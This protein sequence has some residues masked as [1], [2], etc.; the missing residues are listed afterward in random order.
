MIP[1]FRLMAA[2]LLAAGMARAGWPRAF[3]LESPR[4]GDRIEGRMPALGEGWLAYRTRD[5]ELLV[6][7]AAD[8]RTIRRVGFPLEVPV[9]DAGDEPVTLSGIHSGL[10][11][12]G[13]RLAALAWGRTGG[14]LAVRALVLWEIPSGRVVGVRIVPLPDHGEPFLAISESA[15]LLHLPGEQRLERWDPRDFTPGPPLALPEGVD[16]PEAASQIDGADRAWLGERFFVY[17]PAVEFAPLVVVDLVDGDAERIELPAEYRVRPNLVRVAGA[18]S[19]CLVPCWG[20]AETSFSAVAVFDLEAGRFEHA[21]VL[22]GVP[23]GERSHAFAGADGTWHVVAWGDEDRLFSFDRGDPTGGPGIDLALGFD[24]FVSHGSPYR[25][26][27]GWLWLRAGPTAPQSVVSYRIPL[28]VRPQAMIRFRVGKARESDGVVTA[29]WDVDPPLE[30]PLTLRLE[31]V[32]G[33]ARE[34][35]DYRGFSKQVTI[36]AGVASVPVEVALTRDLRIE[37][38]E[39][40]GLRLSGFDD[41]LI[42][43]NPL[44][45]V[46]IEGSTFY[47]EGL[48]EPW[49]ANPEVRARSVA[50]AGGWLVQGNGKTDYDYTLTPPRLARRPLRGGEWVPSGSWPHFDSSNGQPSLMEAAVE[51]EV[52]IYENGRSSLY[53]PAA[54][55][56]V[57]EFEQLYNRPMAVTGG[58]VIGYTLGGGVWQFGWRPGVPSHALP[59]IGSQ[60]RVTWT[61]RFVVSGG[62]LNESIEIGSRGDGRFLRRLLDEGPWRDIEG[63]AAAGDTLVVGGFGGSYLCRLEELD[64]DGGGPLPAIL[65]LRHP[66]EGAVPA[67]AIHVAGERI[68]AVRPIEGPRVRVEVFR[69]ADGEWTGTID[70]PTLGVPWISGFLRNLSVD[71]QDLVLAV[72]RD[73]RLSIGHFALDERIPAIR[74]SVPVREGAGPVPMQLSEAAPWPMVV[75]ARPIDEDLAEGEQWRGL[76]EPVTVPAGVTS[77]RLPLAREH[78]F[79]A[80]EPGMVRLELTVETPQGGGVRVIEVATVDD[81]R[82]SFEQ[83]ERTALP[84]VS[85]LTAFGNGWIGGYYEGDVASNDRMRWTDTP[86]FSV[87]HPLV[88]GA[89]SSSYELVTADDEWAA[90]RLPEVIRNFGGTPA[91]VILFRPREPEAPIRVFRGSDYRDNFGRSVLIDDGFVWIGAPWFDRLSTTTPRAGKVT[92]YDLGTGLVK[93]RITPPAA[94]KWN[95]GTRLVRNAESLWVASPRA[96]DEQGAVTQY[97]AATYALQRVIWAPRV[98]E[99]SAGFGSRLEATGE[100]LIVESP[101]SNPYQPSSFDGYEASTGAHLWTLAGGGMERVG[102]HLLVLTDRAGLWFHD[103]REPARPR[104][105]LH[106]AVAFGRKD[107]WIES[108][109]SLLACAPPGGAVVLDLRQ[110]E[111]LWPVLGPLP[112]VPGVASLF[113]GGVSPL[114]LERHGAG[115]RLPLPAGYAPPEAGELVVECAPH[116]DRWQSVAVLSSEGGWALAADYAGGLRLSADRDAIEV[117]V[118]GSRCFFRLR[119]R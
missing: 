39:H 57:L 68:L 19:T 75:S 3:E 114:E 27:G 38:D 81:D 115:W 101:N 99:A 2:V 83:V 30:R 22:P 84:S 116:L 107:P 94:V 15:L 1:L 74:P 17:L 95:F 62:F 80:S 108:N 117:P 37:D 51:G 118:G 56:R 44:G 41:G 61:D 12:S 86:D 93:K 87:H 18:G 7:D 33:T 76:G 31:T 119:W 113:E 104:L 8:G 36:P 50:L 9:T 69:L 73:E 4:E 88:P 96:S 98:D 60:S 110:F 109:G 5:L 79:L 6:A 10:V 34:G 78:D 112:G 46:V 13:D 92:K 59:W 52:M 71:G 72:E 32:E 97:D 11:A 64:D 54:D 40:L 48:I 35:E 65:P 85:A 90:L 106:L 63:F 29:A 77:F 67:Q 47:G 53:D 45:Q 43:P 42:V 100:L 28:T 24:G 14:G 16:P 23:G 20:T 21:V 102:P 70:S 103:L 25:L 49:T 82:L 55:R 66:L 111:K 26:H 58:A 105:A 89:P 91:E